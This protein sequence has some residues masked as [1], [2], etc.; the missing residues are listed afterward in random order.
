MATSQLN[1]APRKRHTWRWVVGGIIVGFIV[2]GSCSAIASPKTTATPSFPQATAAASAGAAVGAPVYT[3]P[4]AKP[5]ENPLNYP[6][7]PALAGM[8]D[9]FDDGTWVGGEDVKVGRYKTSNVDTSPIKGADLCYFQVSKNGKPLIDSQKFGATQA[10]PSVMV[11]A[12]GETVVT[13][14]CKP[15]VLS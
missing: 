15:W 10:G 3:S 13:S 8:L 6:N 2:L 12:A 11:L 1:P 14:G 5:T 4:E 7:P 9:R